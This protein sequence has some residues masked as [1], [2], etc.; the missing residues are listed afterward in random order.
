M[1]ISLLTT[2]FK[3]LK[4]IDRLKLSPLV[5]V[6]GI[7]LLTSRANNFWTAL[8]RFRQAFVVNLIFQRWVC[9]LLAGGMLYMTSRFVSVFYF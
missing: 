6:F 9:L 3:L 1:I 7:V 8:R 2:S 5:G 4:V